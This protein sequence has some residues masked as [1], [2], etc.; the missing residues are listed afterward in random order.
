MTRLASSSQMAREIAEQPVAVRDTLEALLPRRDQIAEQLRHCRRVLFVARGSSDNAATYGRYL[1]ETHA[2]VQA[3]LAAPSV[4][5]HYRSDLDL[6]DTAVVSVSQSG[7]T[8]EI[9]EAQA[10]AQACGALTVA[11]SNDPGAPLARQAD[12]A[13]TTQ[14]GAE[15]AV[16][17]TKSYLTQVAAL[18]VLGS[19]LGPEDPEFVEA[20][21]GAPDAV[22]E[23]LSVDADSY[24]DVVEHLVGRPVIVAG[25]GLLLGTAL[26]A[27]L[28]LEE[29]CLRPVR[30]YSYAD[31]RHGPIAVVDEGMTAVLFGAPDGPFVT[32]M[33]DLVT[34]VRARG[35]AT[36]G[37]G[38]APWL[39]STDLAV[40]A[41][42]VTE[43]L[44]PLVSIVPMQMVIERLARRLG[45]DPDAPRGLRKV[46][47]SG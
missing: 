3:A 43:R 12:V 21:H 28:K 40:D 35:A 17:A 44:A 4:A 13:L 16:P 24:E 7:R 38:A 8:T 27:A 33:G 46:T 32:A 11:V 22:A 31:L 6:S 15:L 23:A 10:W 18:A 47:T 5:T 39:I 9:V 34:D 36:I 26:E 41:P 30:G 29:T 1:L 20:L 2:G 42:P 25:R 14:G 19:A 45:L 37:V